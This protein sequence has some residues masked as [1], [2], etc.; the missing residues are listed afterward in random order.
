MGFAPSKLDSSLFIWQGQNESVIILL[1]VD[2]LVIANADLEDVSHVK[3]QLVASFK[4]KDQGDL[5]YFLRIEVIH[6]LE[7]I[8]INQRHYVLSMLFK[9]GMTDCKSVSTPLDRNVKIRQGSAPTCDAT[10]FW[11]IVKILI[12]LTITRLDLI[13]PVDLV[14]QFMSQPMVEHLQCAQ[15]PRY[16]S[17]TRLLY[18]NGVSKELFG[19]QMPIG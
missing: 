17:G 8:L 1:Y 14:S 11:N 5:H 19:T 6:T 4:M 12:Y 13:Y 7:G 3:S 18:Q 15:R 16:V 10:R 2:D 9:F